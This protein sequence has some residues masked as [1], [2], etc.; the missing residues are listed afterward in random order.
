MANPPVSSARKPVVPSLLTD[1]ECAPPLGVSVVALPQR[2]GLLAVEDGE[3]SQTCI[4][5]RALP[6]KMRAYSGS[7]GS[8]HRKN[9]WVSRSNSR[10]SS[11]RRLV[12]GDVVEADVVVRHAA[13]RRG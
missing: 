12:P 9:S 3:M 2:H 6:P 4:W 1:R 11:G 13:G 8:S 10:M 5:L 7:K